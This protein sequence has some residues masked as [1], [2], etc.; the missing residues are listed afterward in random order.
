MISWVK[1]FFKKTESFKSELLKLHPEDFS[2]KV[3]SFSFDS[4]GFD[5]RHTKIQLQNEK[6]WHL[7]QFPQQKKS[8]HPI[9]LS[10]SKD[11]KNIWP[12][13]EITPQDQQVLNLFLH[14]TMR[15]SMEE[16]LDFIKAPVSGV[17]TMDYQSEAQ[18]LKWFEVSLTVLDK[19]LDKF[20]KESHLVLTGCFFA[21]KRNDN[22]ERLIRLIIFNLDIFFYLLED[23][24]LRV[25][26]FDDKDKGHG[27][28]QT[29][30]FQQII[31]VTKPQ[32]YDQMILILQKIT[33]HGEFH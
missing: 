11:E 31:K 20:N 12:L 10:T 14:E 17:T 15:S 22:S 28:A 33:Q 24:S 26:I 9:V 27:E 2:W 8:T 13:S 19:A 1:K 25:V 5:R 7:L 4:D 3:I 32:F 21:G 30:A 6:G 23:N 18:F 16:I 29:P